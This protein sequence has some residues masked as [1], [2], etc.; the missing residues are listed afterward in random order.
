MKIKRKIFVLAAMLPVV[1]SSAVNAQSGQITVARAFYELALRNNTQ[2]IGSLLRRGYSIESPDSE[3]N[4]AVCLS[5]VK[6]NRQAYKVLTSFGAKKYPAC[7]NNISGESY[8][9]FFGVS[10]A[11]TEVKPYVPDQPYLIGATVLGAGALAAAYIFRGDTDD[12][13]GSG[14]GSGGGGSGGG[15]DEHNCPANSSY[16]SQTQKCECWGG[17]GNYGDANNCYATIANC[18]TQNKEECSSCKSGYELKENICYATIAN[19]KVQ[20]ENF[21]DECVNGYG[22]HNGDK[23][24]CYA[25]IPN[26]KT[27][28]ESSC[29]ECNSGY[30]TYGDDTRCYADIDHCAIQIQSSCRQCDTGYDTLDS[31]T[32]DVCY[33]RD[34]NPCAQYPN[35][36]PEQ[37]ESGVECVCNYN[38]GYSGDKE[39]CTQA[40]EGNYQEGEGN[41]EEW[42][43]LNEQHCNSHGKYDVVSKRCTCYVGY[44]G[45]SCDKCQAGYNDFSG[46]GICFR[47]LNCEVSQGPEYEQKNDKC[48]C[49]PEYFS[50]EGNCT[51]P[52]DC[53]G[54]KGENYTQ[55]GP[56][57][58]P[59]TACSCKPNFDENCEF[60]MDGF[61]LDE[62]GNCKRVEYVCSEKWTGAE[63]DICPTQYEITVGS[64]GMEHCGMQCAPNRLPI[65]E[66]PDCETCAV[67]YEWSALDNNCIVTECSSGVDGYIKDEEGRCR[68]DTEN[69]YALSASGI[70]VKKGPDYVGIKDSNI[71][72]STIILDNNETRDGFRDVYGMKPVLS[73]DGEGNVEYFD[74]VYNALAS[75]GQSRTGTINITNMN[76][77][78]NFVYGIYSPSTIYNAASINSGETATSAIG[79]INIADTNTA[80]LIH[81]I[82]SDSGDSIY[83]AFSY[84]DGSASLTEPSES[85]ATALIAINKYRASSETGLSN[86]TG[87]ITGMNGYGNVYNAYAVTTD[88]TAANVASTGTI[89]IVHE[90]DGVVTGIRGENSLAKINNAMSFLDSAVSNALSK[91]EIILSG[92]NDVYGIYTKGSV[93][94]SETQ[95]NKSFNIIKDFRSEGII[96][97]TTNSAIKSAYGI[98]IAGSADNKIDVY[99]AMGYNSS[100]TITVA[101]TSGGSAYGIWNNSSTYNS[102]NEQGEE[103]KLY[104]NTYN[105]FRSSAKYGGDNT[106]ADGTVTVNISGSNDGMQ[107]AIGIYAA[108]DVFNA[109]TKSGSAVKLETIGSIIINDNSLSS[110]MIL[111]GLEGEG[112]TVANAYSTGDNQNTSTVVIGNIAVNINGSKSG[113]AG[114]AFGIY[115]TKS[116]P[117]IA[118][119]YNAALINDKNNVKGTITV[120]SADKKN[121]FSRLYGMY[122]S[123]Y[124]INGG[125]EYSSQPKM[126]YNAY[127]GNDDE[128]QSEGSVVGTINVTTTGKS[129]SSIAEYYGMYINGGTNGIRDS[130]AYNAYSSNSNADVAGII[131]VDVA[132]GENEAIAAGMYANNARLYN[133]GRKSSINVTTSRAGSKAYGMKGDDSYLYNNAAI[134]ATSKASAAY[135]MYVN[136]GEAI[137]DTNG[138]ITVT[139]KT[140]SYGMYV[141]AD[142]T[143]RAFAQN[144][145]TINVNGEGTNVG[146]YASGANAT[147]ENKGII[148]INGVK[149][150]G[151]ECNGGLAVQL[152]D[153]ASFVNGGTISSDTSINLASMGGDVYLV[154]DGKFEAKDSITGTI[155]IAANTLFDTFDRQTVLKDAVS[156]DNTSGVGINSKSYIYQGSLQKNENGTY[157]V[158]MQMKDW[159]DLTNKS[160]A[161]YLKLNQERERN[162]SLYNALKTAETNKAFTSLKANLMG[163]DMLPNITEEELKVQRSLDKTMM[164]D[165]FK[166]NN[167]NVRKVIG[168]DALYIGRDDKGTLTGY[169]TSAQSAYALYDQKLN[170]NY[171]LGLGFS[172]T[173]TN[174]DYNNDSSRKNFMV[175]GYIPFI[176]QNKGLTAVSMARL[177]YADG[178]YKRRGNDQ[179]YQADINE[180]TYGLLNEARYKINLGMVNLTPFIGLN[181]IGWYQDSISEGSRDLAINLASSHVFS[182][183][184]ALGIYVDKE[185]EFNED[186]KLNAVLGIGWY[187]EFADPYRGFDARHSSSLSSYCL[188][189]KDSLS[190]RDRGIV[191][192]KINYDYKD[193]SIYGELMQYL[194]DE[195]PLK[196]EGG[197]KYRF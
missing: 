20:T 86:N 41:E 131:N 124:E 36:F 108:G 22:T 127:Y 19:C 123:T 92:N 145:G 106:A 14:G 68:C 177:G 95:F 109:Y 58:D 197:L 194:E 175:Q 37:T 69:G 140:A 61:E 151:N 56:G 136:R 154:E 24:R 105:A 30:G 66:N 6:Q 70:C 152:E 114:Q 57:P 4:N 170:N 101:N 142:D 23:T 120:A 162:N 65:E 88:G 72:N 2:K 33:K 128:T 26:C 52:V 153:G 98:Y 3:G 137:N 50:Y 63:C 77:G 90:G 100:G 160:E 173:H 179:T 12:G 183:E 117:S 45:E 85:T 193:F 51:L 103:T 139:G 91:G 64:D 44:A 187:H 196:V 60:C 59:E 130:A 74:N 80:S 156:A 54:Y 141:I 49:K 191:S 47:D 94:N 38:K 96:D 75:T 158:V 35:T 186:S 112:A 149:C 165:L 192:A 1:F 126:V 166:S 161:D 48:V 168:A 182:L 28:Q 164:S 87:D 178:D 15:E 81:G 5:V 121:T 55:T 83:N 18:K 115:N 155:N 46:N 93:A 147:V 43:N 8:R 176:Y 79:N 62:N 174:T 119:I 138:V 11:T 184:S 53:A 134:N 171:R 9:R 84:A 135:G 76:T 40:G 107:R 122:V 71:N 99:N 13:N 27:Q 129:L 111:R 89:N 144:L 102:Q 32:A 195:Y 7:L 116:T 159:N 42:S 148:N 181:A 78:A 110:N 21:C 146:I 31:P 172:F 157:D 133:S 190:S 163:T 167:E 97:A 25:D 17:Y 188:K 113:S 16:N 67:G 185:I 82:Y 189:N 104:N 34:E 118:K 150:N 10:R 125:D 180:I 169:D 132:G 29:S 39:N 143:E 73:D